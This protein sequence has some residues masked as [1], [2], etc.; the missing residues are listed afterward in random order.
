M[1]Q[2][3]MFGKRLRAAVRIVAAGEDKTIGSVQ[4]DLGYAIGRKGRTAIQYF[5]RGHTLGNPSDIEILARELLKQGGF[6]KQVEFEQFLHS[7]GYPELLEKILG[8]ISP[9][10]IEPFPPDELLAPFVVGM[11]ITN[12]QQFFGREKVLRDIGNALAYSPLQHVA[13]IGPY[14]SGKTS[15]LHYLRNMTTTSAQLRSGQRP[16]WLTRLSGYRWIFVDFQYPSMQEQNKLLQYL[17]TELA[18]PVPDS[19]YS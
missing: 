14:R 16:N 17:L 15:L 12:P 3:L 9:P 13:I 6:R 7:P 19:I 1:A 11:P 4:D 10:I 18:I 5:E 2:S 8:V